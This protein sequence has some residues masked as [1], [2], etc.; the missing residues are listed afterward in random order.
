MAELWRSRERRGWRPEFAWRVRRLSCQLERFMMS[1]FDA[2]LASMPMGDLIRERAFEA[3][4]PPAF[5]ISFQD[6]LRYFR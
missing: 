4:L 2:M 6:M 1:A 5:A 3:M